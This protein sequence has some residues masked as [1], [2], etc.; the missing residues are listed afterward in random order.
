MINDPCLWVFKILASR[1]MGLAQK[2]V[3]AGNENVLE[4]YNSEQIIKAIS[5]RWKI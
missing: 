1:L 2:G 3:V 4:S 5:F